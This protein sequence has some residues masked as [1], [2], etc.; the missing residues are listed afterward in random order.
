MAEER[1]GVPRLCGGLGGTASSLLVG[2][3]DRTR[4]KGGVQV[5]P[6][7]ARLGVPSTLRGRGCRGR[8]A[9]AYVPASSCYAASLSATHESNAHAHMPSPRGHVCMGAIYIACVQACSLGPS[10]ALVIRAAELPGCRHVGTTQSEAVGPRRPRWSTSL[11][12]KGSPVRVRASALP[13][14]QGFL[15]HWQQRRSLAG[16]KACACGV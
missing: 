3:R 12:M 1:G 2:Q 9:G 16:T 6:R 7:E 13:V 4:W 10:Q 14:L 8:P 15:L 11:V 5:L